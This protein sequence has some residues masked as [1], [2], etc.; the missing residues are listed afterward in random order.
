MGN[1]YHGGLFTAAVADYYFNN[2]TVFADQWGVY[3]HWT[4]LLEWWTS[5]M[6]DY[7]N[8]GARN[9]RCSSRDYTHAPYVF[10]RSECVFCEVMTQERMDG[11]SV[12]PIVIEDNSPVKLA[13]RA[14]VYR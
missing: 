7:W 4:G 11:T 6:V 5:G 1:N 12:N 14:E 8:T 9:Y 13:R 10:L 3:K 2:H